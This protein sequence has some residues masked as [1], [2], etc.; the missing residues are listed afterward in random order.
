MPPRGPRARLRRRP[1]RAPA[2]GRI[3]TGARSETDTRA[4]RSASCRP[5]ESSSRDAGPF[6]PVPPWD[7]RLEGYLEQRQGSA[8][9]DRRRPSCSPDRPAASL[10]CVRGVSSGGLRQNVSSVARL[11]APPRG[12]RPSGPSRRTAGH[13]NR[14]G[15]KGPRR[16]P[17]RPSEGLP[18]KRHTS[19]QARSYTTRPFPT[20]SSRKKGR[21][22]SSVLNSSG[23]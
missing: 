7:S 15:C 16:V 23:V 2:D 14:S 19:D 17:A 11:L 6:R 22:R 5:R 20:I 8:K 9:A 3:G 4:T 21:S 13:G 10:Q 1:G 18:P 12:A